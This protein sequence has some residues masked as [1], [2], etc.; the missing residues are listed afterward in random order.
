MT[1]LPTKKYISPEEYLAAERIA[2]TK[3]EY[4]NGEIFAMA[5]SSFRHALISTNVGSNLSMKLKGKDCRALQ[6]DLRVLIP[7][8]GLYTYP[9]VSVVCGSPKLVDDSHF[10]ILL[11]PIVII[12]VLSPSTEAYDKGIKFDHYRTIESLKEYVLV[13]QDKKR[14]ARYTRQ[15][16]GGWN[17]HDFIGDGA[18]IELRSIGCTLTM[19]DIYDKVEFED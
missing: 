2:D 19:D 10:D 13:W 11:N 1:A 9:D 18:D 4:F 14:V 7:T 16:D 12:E 15:D 3:H 17:L 5:G 6:S 8:T